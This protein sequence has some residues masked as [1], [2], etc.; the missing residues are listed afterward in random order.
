MLGGRGMLPLLTTVSYPQHVRGNFDLLLTVC[1]RAPKQSCRRAV[2][3]AAFAQ[4]DRPR[5][6]TN[7]AKRLTVVCAAFEPEVSRRTERYG[8]EHETHGAVSEPLEPG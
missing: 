6:A 4:E 1:G 5:A 3:A 7:Y 8:T 2:A